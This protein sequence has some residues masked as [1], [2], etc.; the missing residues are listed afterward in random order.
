MSLNELTQVKSNLVEMIKSLQ[1]EV[2]SLK[3][4]ENIEPK[5]PQLEVKEP[6]LIDNSSQRD[7]FI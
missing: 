2:I 3:R 7:F 4:K 6:T 1:S 5:T